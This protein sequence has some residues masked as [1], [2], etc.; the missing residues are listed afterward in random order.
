MKGFVFFLLNLKSKVVYL[1]LAQ[2]QSSLKSRE[3]GYGVK[4]YSS[5]VIFHLIRGKNGLVKRGEAFVI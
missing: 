1:I 5:R 4:V 3:I 2:V